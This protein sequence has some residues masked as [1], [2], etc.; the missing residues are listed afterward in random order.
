MEY[1]ERESDEEDCRVP[2]EMV[3][4]MVAVAVGCDALV[5]ALDCMRAAVRA[6]P[7]GGL[8]FVDGML[9]VM[10]FSAERVQ[11]EARELVEE[12]GRLS[13]DVYCERA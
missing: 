3:A 8:S 11:N 10:L 9:E 4:H 13:A 5:Q 1:L 12:A 7:D 6:D 2:E